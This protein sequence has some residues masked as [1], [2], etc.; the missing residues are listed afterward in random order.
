MTPV[1]MTSVLIHDNTNLFPNPRTYNPDP[2]L[3]QPAFKGYLVPLSRGSR[4]CVGLNLANAQSYLALA[5]VFAPARFR[6]ELFE[7]DISDLETKHDFWNTSP[8][9]GSEGILIVV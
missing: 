7:T 4:L 2:F 5:A 8:R 9:L 1:N 3:E 6:L